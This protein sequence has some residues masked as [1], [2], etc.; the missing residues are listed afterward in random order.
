MPYL[1]QRDLWKFDWTKHYMVRGT[2][3]AAVHGKPG[4][5][6]GKA[7]AKDSQCSIQDTINIKTRWLG[8]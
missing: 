1:R 4:L 5:E 3:G 2:I 8:D 7:E 6:T